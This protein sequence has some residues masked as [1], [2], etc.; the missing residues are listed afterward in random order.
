MA[1]N[2]SCDAVCR[3]S[4]RDGTEACW[5]LVRVTRGARAGVSPGRRRAWATARQREHTAHTL[6]DHKQ[7]HVLTP[8]MYTAASEVLASRWECAYIDS[9]A[10]RG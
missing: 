4:N 8:C 3:T 1:N 7:R 5:R 9:A 2:Y 6:L 10:G